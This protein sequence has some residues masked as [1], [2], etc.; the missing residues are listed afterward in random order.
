MIIY[1][2]TKAQFQKDALANQMGPL[3]LREYTNKTG[4]ITSSSEVI[5]WQNSLLYMSSILN[6][7]EIP[8][9]CG[10]AVEY[11]I[12]QTSKRIDFIITGANEN[13][14]DHAILIELKQWS[15][16]ELTGKDGIVKTRLGGA[17]QEVNHPSYQVWSYAAL[18]EDFNETVSEKSIHIRP[19]AY[20]H[21]Y[22]ENLY[23]P[24][25]TNDF[26]KDYLDKAPVFL[27]SDA[28]KLRAFIKHFVKRGDSTNILYQIDSGRIRPSKQLSDMVASMLDGND[29]YVMLDEQKVVFE[30]AMSLSRHATDEKKNVLI[31]E[32]GP[33]TGKSVI[34]INLLAN[35]TK[36]GKLAKY[37]TRNA[38]PRKVY[39]SKLVG[40]LKPSQIWSLF[41]GS[42]SFYNVDANA[43]HTL[44]VDEAHRLNEKSGLYNNQGEHQIKE[45]INAAK[46]SIFF[47]DE[48]QRVTLKDIGTKKEIEYFAQE[49]GANIHT[50]ELTSQF[51]CNG[52]D[53]YLSWLDDV[54]Q[55]RETANYAFNSD[56]YDFKVVDSPCELRDII[57]QK[58]K[59][60]NKARIVAG[61]CWPWKSKKD[62][63]AYDFVF[64]DCDFKMRWNLTVDGGLWILMPNSVNEIGV[65]H[66][67]QGLE[68]DY[69][70]VIIGPDLIVRDGK[71][72]TNP[73]A[74]AGDDRTL[75]GYKT[76]MKT[77]PIWTEKLV[78]MIIKN[79]YRTLLTRG[80]KGCY[81]YCT[82]EETRKYFKERL[83]M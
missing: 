19:C 36:M 54:L 25:V 27:Q 37:V 52:S 53:G 69:I 10:V 57:F 17:L 62:P 65:I 8:D 58:N 60:N 33:G 70:G 59:I 15:E 83:S 31:I 49:A 74:R 73:E 16:A 77:D 51:R 81:V 11:Q 24:V 71:V 80:M 32:G 72:I 43:Y 5:S 35:I 18:L 67:C 76:R 82:D 79:T 68:V 3:I 66:T 22:A 6:D 63:A 1:Q 46:L 40:H 47:I 26:Y 4:R 64:S 78:D 29:E 2:A 14:Q 75:A 28:Q 23:Q 41:T 42:G 20:L 39:E 48:D 44:I 9:D 12:P 45:I 56:S 7:E 34:A 55:L 13:G 61:Y 21:N 50:Y 30:T 38:A